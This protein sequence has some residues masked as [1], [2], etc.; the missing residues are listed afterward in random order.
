MLSVRRRHERRRESLCTCPACPTDAMDVVL[1]L[2]R[3]LVIED[4]LDALDVESPRGD[5]R[6]NQDRCRSRLPGSSHKSK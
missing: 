2:G 4:Q 3:K 1:S 6:R 5:I